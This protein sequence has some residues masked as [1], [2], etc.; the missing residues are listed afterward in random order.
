MNYDHE[1]YPTWHYNTYH[2]EK[3]Y[4]QRYKVTF[5]KGQ[6]TLS[7]NVHAE[8]AE[9]ATFAATQEVY[10]NL[11]QIPTSIKHVSTILEP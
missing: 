9:K 1:P 5:T 3:F 6:I 2:K 8:S 7:L 4:A 10:K 11:G